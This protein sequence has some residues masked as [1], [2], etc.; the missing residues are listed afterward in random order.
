MGYNVNKGTVTLMV[1]VFYGCVCHGM[2]L[3]VALN[4]FLKSRKMGAW[5]QQARAALASTFKVL[6]AK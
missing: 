4:H 3:T 6:K 2:L 1:Y 5:D